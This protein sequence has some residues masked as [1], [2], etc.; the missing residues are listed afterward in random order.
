MILGEGEKIIREQFWLKKLEAIEQ[1]KKS[2]SQV[3]VK[4][5]LV[6]LSCFTYSKYVS[7]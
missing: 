7:E 5:T 1:I 6:G 2:Y 4:Q 3:L